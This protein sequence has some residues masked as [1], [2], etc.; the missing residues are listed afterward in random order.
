MQAGRGRGACSGKR[1]TRPE[2]AVEVRGRER[3]SAALLH[4]VLQRHRRHHQADLDCAAHGAHDCVIDRRHRH[5]AVVD[6]SIARQ[7]PLLYV[8]RQRGRAAP[9]LV[10]RQ[11]ARHRA[12][13]ART[14]ADVTLQSKVSSI[15]YRRAADAQTRVRSD[16]PNE[17]VVSGCGRPTPR[18]ARRS[19][20]PERRA[21]H[22]GLH[23]LNR[24]AHAVA[25]ASAGPCRA[26]RESEL[27]LRSY[28]HTAPLRAAPP[29]AA[30]CAR[31]ASSAFAPAAYRL[32]AHCGRVS[33]RVRC[34]AEAGG[35]RRDPTDAVTP[36]CCQRRSAARQGDTAASCSAH[37]SGAH[38]CR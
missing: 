11:C 33:T 13:C 7:A 19:A 3:H 6:V 9:P 25:A 29:H 23:C 37:C 32:R 12:R 20:P 36:P 27:R 30:Q 14:L 15:A 38:A 5:V 16:D 28:A 2:A 10:R 35:R 31:P 17:R 24:R 18:A 4:R 8:H 21:R 34:P 22:F 26:V 1:A